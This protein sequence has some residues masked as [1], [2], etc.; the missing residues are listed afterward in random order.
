M[1]RG[2]GACSR[3]AYVRPELGKAPTITVP[4][5]LTD[6][7]VILENYRDESIGKEWVLVVNR[8]E[9]IDFFDNLSRNFGK[10]F[11]SFDVSM[12]MSTSILF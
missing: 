3:L 7:L 4:V 10:I 11:R 8:M 6:A 2:R 12:F 5:L 1:W 9:I